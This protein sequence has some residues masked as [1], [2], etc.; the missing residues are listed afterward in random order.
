[1]NLLEL[2]LRVNYHIK[3][4]VNSKKE[5]NIPLITTLPEA[6]LQIMFKGW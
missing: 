5:G 4:R 6:V 1:M 2:Q 3:L